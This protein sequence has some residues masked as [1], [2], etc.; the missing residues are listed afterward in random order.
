MNPNDDDKVLQEIYR[1]GNDDQPPAQLDQIILQHAQ[2]SHATKSK[3]RSWRPWL[4]AASVVLVLP[5]IWILVQNEQ[6]LDRAAPNAQLTQPQKPK[7]AK[8]L[9]KQEFH[10]EPE[11]V[12]EEEVQMAPAE[13]NQP[14]A[15]SA[16]MAS[17][18]DDAT[19]EDTYGKITV[20]GSRIR[21]EDPESLETESVKA[22]RE[23]L[24][25]ELKTKKKSLKQSNLDPI[26][27]MELQRFDMYLEE[28]KIDQ[29]AQ[30]LQEMQEREPDFDYSELEQRL[31]DT[32]SD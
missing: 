7:P 31:A 2:Q 5:M 8:E 32:G 16:D 25:N 6:L 23:I 11:P 3:L 20:T 19:L 28:G 26:L 22:N 14:A 9:N 10:S 4:A 27:A 13:S 12:L 18:A 1:S 29:A 30:L 15:P 24:L 21:R 17:E